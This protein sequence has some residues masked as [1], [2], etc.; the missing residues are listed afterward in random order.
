MNNKKN[1]FSALIFQFIS[2]IYGLVVS[3]LIIATFGSSVNGLVSSVIQFLSFISL[4]E[5][6]LGAVVLAELYLP[7]ENNNETKIKKILY[8]C[9]KAFKVIGFVFVIYTIILSVV[10]PIIIKTTFD[11][12]YVCSLILILSLNN[13]AQYLFSITKKIYLQANQKLYC[14]NNLNT[15]IYVINLVI[16][17]LCI[18]VWPSI[19]ALKLFTS[20]AF[21]IQPFILNLFIDKRFKKIVKEDDKNYQLKNR[22]SGFGQHFAH[23]INLNTDIVL[24]SIFL[25]L[26]EASVYAVYMLVINALRNI[27]GMINNAYQSAL[28][29][30]YVQDINVL[31]NK[32][33]EF[34]A[35]NSCLST[36][37]FMTCLLLINSFVKLHTSGISDV[38]YYQPLFA[39]I[40]C[41][42]YY[43]FS[44]R[45]PY[46]ML[47][48]STGK[49]KE[50]NFGS[51]GEA[52]I[53]IVLSVILI[54]VCGL[55]GV[56]IGTLV[57]VCFRF[58]HFIWY[59]RKKNMQLDVKHY[60]INLSKTF[61]FLTINILIYTNLNIECNSILS[62]VFGGIVIFIIELVLCS[63][64]FLGIKNIRLYIKR[65][66]K[67][68]SR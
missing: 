51:F 44:L 22:W 15:A 65:F 68:S 61:V 5:G 2:I 57:A 13:I 26:G 23:F 37:V 32:F 62:F 50:T 54:N 20:I 66:L 8:S 45:E 52:L 64:T 47:A 11:F 31:K 58:A 19:H 1:I 16:T 34:K 24:V 49:F 42:A 28:G 3:R 29:K 14:V 59:S 40:I 17:L 56:A 41:V 39:L 27:V 38:N 53:N 18:Y 10:Y 30:Y 48:L 25:S 35:L 21:F 9:Q 43:V 60:L 36:T 4:L 63:F 33:L 12:S 55:V 6:G 67:N 7:I 46:R